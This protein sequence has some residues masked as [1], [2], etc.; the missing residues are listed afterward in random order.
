MAEALKSI[1]EWAAV[2]VVMVSVA[3]VVLEAG[4]FGVGKARILCWILAGLEDHQEQHVVSDC[5]E[6]DYLADCATC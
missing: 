6:T 5:V 4:D 3:L 2:Q 1:S